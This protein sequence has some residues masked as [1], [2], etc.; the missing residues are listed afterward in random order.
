MSEGR[1]GVRIMSERGGEMGREEG[2]RGR[3]V[4]VGNRECE[5]G[6]EERMENVG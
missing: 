2:G 4:R 5:I 6:W 1:D 3:M